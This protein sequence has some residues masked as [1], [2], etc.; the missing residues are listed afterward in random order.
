MHV[1]IQQRKNARGDGVETELIVGTIAAVAVSQHLNENS[2][3]GRSSADSASRRSSTA[4]SVEW[5]SSV[6]L[7]LRKVVLD[8]FERAAERDCRHLQIFLQDRVS[9]LDHHF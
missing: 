5:Q 9:N 2:S 7:R 1:A 8:P 6:K 3:H 4:T